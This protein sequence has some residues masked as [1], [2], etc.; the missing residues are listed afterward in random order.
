MRNTSSF[1]LTLAL[2]VV[3]CPSFAATVKEKDGR[4]VSGEIK[5]RIALKSTTEQVEQDSKKYGVV[6][7]ALAD[8]KYIEA[9]DE[10][11]VSLHGGTIALLLVWW[12]LDGK[13]RTPSELECL[14]A[15]NHE[16]KGFPFFYLDS[17]AGVWRF[18]KDLLPKSSAGEIFGAIHQD[19]TGSAPAFLANPKLNKLLGE[20]RSGQ[21]QERLVPGLEVLTADGIVKVQVSELA[22]FR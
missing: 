19:V 7:Y 4:I 15:E 22:S 13:D 11:G 12:E 18:Y 9:I 3:T 14:T 5:G 6:F 10:N 1:V 8:G 20:I 17:G 2:L 21:G 16:P